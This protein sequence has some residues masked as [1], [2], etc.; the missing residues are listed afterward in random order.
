M[1]RLCTLVLLILIAAGELS[2]E[3][4]IYFSGFVDTLSTVGLTGDILAS[5]ARFRPELELYNG[6]FYLMTTLEAR[7]SE[8]DPLES[9]IALKEAFIEYAGSSF[10]I[11]GGRQIVVWGK[12]DGVE[13]TDIVSPKDYTGFS[14]EE[15]EDTRLPVIALKGRAFGT[16]WTVETIW[17]PL[18]TPAQLPVSPDNPLREAL[19]PSSSGLTYQFNDG[20]KP[21]RLKDSEFGGR[22]SFFLPWGDFSFCGFSGWNDTPWYESSLDGSTLTL[23]PEY[24]RIWM[25]GMDAAVPFASFVFRA[26]GA[27]T[28]NQ[29]FRDSADDSNYHVRDGLKILGGLDWNPG[30][31]WSLTGQYFEDW[32]LGH[33]D[34]IGRD[35]RTQSVS[36]SLSKSLLRECLELSVMG[37]LNLGDYDSYSF[38]QADYAFTDAFHLLGGVV[39]YLPGPENDGEYGAYKDVSNIWVKG[40]FTY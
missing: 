3:T 34:S 27:F 31:G 6:N 24:Y 19:Y 8:K 33:G 10:D 22:I 37:I 40:R 7:Y 15:Y 9:E 29:R 21:S 35:Q 17:I 36:L 16:F 39:L 38:Y 26:E 14:G 5:W 32:V 25:G 30:G 2:A 13:I 4:E 12:A 11:R 28:G 20:T 23:N 1:K 18:F